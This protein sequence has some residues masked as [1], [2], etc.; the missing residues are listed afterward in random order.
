MIAGQTFYLVDSDNN[1]VLHWQTG[2]NSPEVL[3]FTGLNQPDGIAMDLSYNVWVADT[4]NNRVLLLPPNSSATQSVLS[5]T[6]LKNPH[7]VAV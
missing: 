2:Q 4:G 7:G 3:N 1:R 5:F 6:G